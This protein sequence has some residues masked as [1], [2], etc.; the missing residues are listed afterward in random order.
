[1]QSAGDP[2]QEHCTASLPPTRRR[3]TRWRTARPQVDPP[4]AQP[5]QAPLQQQR[6]AAARWPLLRHQ[7]L[8]DRCSGL[9][10]RPRLWQE[11]LGLAIALPEPPTVPSREDGP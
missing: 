1:M 2:P 9:L 7:H 8:A 4:L 11:E 6:Q 3:V 10:L 5:A